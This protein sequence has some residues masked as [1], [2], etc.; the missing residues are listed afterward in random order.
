MEI[1]WDNSATTALC[2]EALAAMSA[3]L[4]EEYGNPSSL[5]QRGTAAKKRLE[6]ARETLARH[7]CCEKEALFFTGS[8]TESNNLALLGAARAHRRE[9]T[10]IVMS[11]VEHPSVLLAGKQLEREGFTLRYVAPDVFGQI[12]AEAFLAQV[13]AD[14]LL[15]S[16]QAVN[17][18][19]G[20]IQPVA[21]IFR[22]A[23]RRFPHLITHCDAIQAFG[24]LPVK[25]AAL[26]ADLLSL[27]AHKIHGPKG[28][29]AL[30]R[31]K[32]L[33]LQSLLYGGAQEQNLRPGTEAL[34]SIL[35]F[36]AAVEALP[37]LAATT[38]AVTALRDALREPLEGM[39]G[40]V[41]NS[42]PTASPYILNCSV[43][44][45][46]SETLLHFLSARGIFCSSGSACSKGQKSPVLTAMGLPPHRVDSALRLSFARTNRPDEIPPFLEALRE[47]M[48]TL[49]KGRR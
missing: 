14:T 31:R 42:S 44:G 40:I 1:Y 7:L 22:A 16:L 48:T 38:A 23:K 43:P 4:A 15:I 20:A 26:N 47:G 35:G 13:D 17:Q 46:R 32:S 2:P 27:S 39:A 6:A 24:K 36:A 9:G 33:R 5:H 49:A 19:T 10:R 37:P 18:E 28:V 45:L 11:A 41:L 30:Y 29:A 25:P 12:D 8:G 21:E 34:P 3:A